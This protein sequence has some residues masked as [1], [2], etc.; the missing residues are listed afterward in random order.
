M[1]KQVEGTGTSGAQYQDNCV[2]EKWPCP[3]EKEEPW[4]GREITCYYNTLKISFKVPLG[5]NEFEH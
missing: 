3:S 1:K 4:D 2:Q 5:R